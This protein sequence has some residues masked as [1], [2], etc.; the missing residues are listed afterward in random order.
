LLTPIS[1]K[2]SSSFRI[3]TTD[4]EDRE[5][6]YIRK[7]LFITMREG[8]DIGRTEVM[9]SNQRVGSIADHTINFITS[10]P[11]YDGFY[12]YVFIPPQCE[13]PFASELT[14]TSN[15]PLVENL[16]CRV[17]GNRVT[18]EVESFDGKM[19]DTGSNISIS[20]SNIK[21]PTSTE[22]T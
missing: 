21:N 1:K 13:A 17:N 15:E 11:L 6:N 9:T 10:T 18:I 22:P 12:V 20:L 7:A 14:C 19:I 8:K 4:N 3:W 2:S 5:I 16:N